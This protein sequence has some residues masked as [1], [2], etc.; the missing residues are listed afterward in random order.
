MVVRRLAM[1]AVAVT[2]V[3]CGLGRGPAKAD[4]GLHGS[5]LSR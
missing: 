4:N 5:P 3:G 1:V 2:L